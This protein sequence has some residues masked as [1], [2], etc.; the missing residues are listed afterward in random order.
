MPVKLPEQPDQVKHARAKSPRRGLT[1]MEVMVTMAVIGI[2][3]ASSTTSIIRTMEQVNVDYAGAGLRSIWNA[4][5]L[6]WVEHRAYAPTVA[7]LETA[8]LLDNSLDSTKFD[9]V[10]ASATSGAFLAEAQRVGSNRWSGT[11]SIDQDGALSGTIAG[12]TDILEPGF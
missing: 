6:Y 4:Q 1:L 2:V 12:G 11:L 8:E 7:D 3:V 5:R 9:F 10:I